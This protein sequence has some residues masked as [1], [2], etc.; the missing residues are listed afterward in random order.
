MG[1]QFYSLV[2]GF[3]ESEIG[4]AALVVVG[5]LCVACRRQGAK[6]FW[7]HCDIRGGMCE[8]SPKRDDE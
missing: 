3:F 7:F 8:Q 1:Y 6:S 5:L 2:L 4:L